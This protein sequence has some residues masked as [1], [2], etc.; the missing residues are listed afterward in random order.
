MDRMF[1]VAVDEY[2]KWPEVEIM[3]STTATATVSVLRQM[4]ARHGIPDNIVTDNGPQFISEEMSSFT[5]KNGIKHTLSAPYHPASNGL[6]E[7][8][9]QSFKNSLKAEKKTITV[10]QKLANFLLAYRN[11][12]HATGE[13]PAILKCG[14]RLKTRLDL[15]KPNLRKTVQ[16]RQAASMDPEKAARQLSPGQHVLIRSYRTGEKWMT[17]VVL[18]K[19]GILSYKV[20]GSNGTVARRHIDQLLDNTTGA[21]TNPSTE[22]MSSDIQRDIMRP[23]VNG[24]VT[25]KPTIADSVNTQGDVS[26]Q[27]SAESNENPAQGNVS[28]QCDTGCSDNPAPVECD[29]EGRPI[30]DRLP[31]PVS[32]VPRRNPVRSRRA[33]NKLDL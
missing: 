9:V 21:D 8:F 25:T 6:A 26:V 2:S 22:M 11:T 30:P 17:G 18:E 31:E 4:F 23:M 14:R 20:R 3:K 16:E 10:E 33:P 15:V 24:S 19:T 1:M 29:L 32:S 13:T 27:C 28:V 12:P 5:K 7:R